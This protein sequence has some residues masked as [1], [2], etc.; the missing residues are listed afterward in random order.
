ML[1]KKKFFTAVGGY[2]QGLTKGEGNVYFYAIPNEE[3]NLDEVDKIINDEM[4]IILN[5]GISEKRFEIEKKKYIFDS[6][7]SRDG[8]LN[9]AQAI[10]ESLTIGF[11]LDDIENLNKKINE[12]TIVDVKEALKSFQENKNFIIGGLKS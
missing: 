4:K 12:I 6:I 5:Q 9:P 7:Y 11:S 8:I 2:Y 3:I 1:I 10:G